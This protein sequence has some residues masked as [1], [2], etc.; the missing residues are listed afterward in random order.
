MDFPLLVE[1]YALAVPELD[2]PAIESAI[3]EACQ[4]ARDKHADYE[5]FLPAMQ[6]LATVFFTD[7]RAMPLDAYLETLYCAVKH[8]DFAK[9]WR[10]QLKKPAFDQVH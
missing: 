10:L 7:H 4:R 8:G 6:F 9:A 1:S 5:R 2:R 3:A